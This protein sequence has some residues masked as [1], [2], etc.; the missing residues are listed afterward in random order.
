M[1]TTA[2]LSWKQIENVGKYVFQ[3]SKTLELEA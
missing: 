1:L 3:T 2:R